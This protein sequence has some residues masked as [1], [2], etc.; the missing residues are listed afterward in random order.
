MLRWLVL[1]LI[2]GVPRLAVSDEAPPLSS[3][4]DQLIDARAGGPPA[5]QASD[6][7][8]LRRVY[9]DLAGRVPSVSE[10][11]QFLARPAADKRQQLIDK[12][13][14]SDDHVRR[15]T[16]V[17]N[18]MLMERLGDHPDWQKFLH[19]SFQTNKPWDQLCRDLLSPNSDDETTRGAALWYTKRLEKYGENPV[20]LPGLVRDVGRQFLGIDV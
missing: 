15:M 19:E 6:T 4:I 12:L 2:A 14:A 8:F 20:D 17:F 5:G 1:L 7:E 9:L 10:T 11:H 3:R 16:Q 13:L 18:V